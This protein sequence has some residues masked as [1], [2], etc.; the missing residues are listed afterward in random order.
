MKRISVKR[1]K[2]RKISNE[3]EREE[4]RYENEKNSEDLCRKWIR[5][6]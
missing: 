2:R 1:K 6:E 5:E 4:N 3:D